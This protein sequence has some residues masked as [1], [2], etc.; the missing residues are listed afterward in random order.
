MNVLPWLAAAALSSSAVAAPPSPL[1]QGLGL[2]PAVLTL[3]AGQ[4]SGK[5]TLSLG[6]GGPNC[7]DMDVQMTVSS[8]GLGPD[9]QAA[10]ATQSVTTADGRT[11]TQWVPAPDVRVV[12]A[13]TRL[14]PGTVQTVR[15]VR[16][17]DPQAPERAYRLRVQELP[18]P[19]APGEAGVRW[20]A[21]LSSPWFFRTAT[22]K[23]DLSAA[24]LDGQLWLINRGTATARVDGVTCGT[25]AQNGLVGYVPPGGRLKISG[26]GACLTVSVTANGQSDVLQ[27]Q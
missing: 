2:S 4:T 8:V 18:P 21:S 20:V 1:C 9:G 23:A 27:V 5:V 15:W 24:R 10:V 17:A 25:D 12:P 16:Q 7:P 6:A 3:P 19:R 14:K 13:I 11:E 26:K 22:A